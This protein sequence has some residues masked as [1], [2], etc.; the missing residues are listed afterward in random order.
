MRSVTARCTTSNMGSRW[1]KSRLIAELPRQERRVRCG[2]GGA[3]L[4]GAKE[5]GPGEAVGCDGP[6][7]PSLKT[8]PRP[9]L[10]L[11]TEYAVN[12]WDPR[13]RDG[14]T[15]AYGQL[16]DS[17]S[18]SMNNLVSRFS[19]TSNAPA[20][21]RS[22]SFTLKCLL[23]VMAFLIFAKSSSL[24]EN[25]RDDSYGVSRMALTRIRQN[26]LARQTLLPAAVYHRVT[27]LTIHFHCLSSQ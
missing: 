18:G 6:A 2:F 14:R 24:C 5:E 10:G 15:T 13:W 4:G 17:S 9:P 21:D 16:S 1:A 22:V 25:L 20:V 26:R 3:R 19:T 27:T 12:K 23:N 7:V 8:P 11:T